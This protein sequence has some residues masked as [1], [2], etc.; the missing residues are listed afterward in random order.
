[1]EAAAFPSG[2]FAKTGGPFIL[3]FIFV[4]GGILGDT[5]FDRKYPL[6]SHMFENS[7]CTFQAHSTQ[8]KGF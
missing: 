4:F 7:A 5:Y 8:T 3:G 6:W 2:G 1:M